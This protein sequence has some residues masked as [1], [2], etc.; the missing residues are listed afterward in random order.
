M[1][2]AEV[3]ELVD[4]LVEEPV[5]DAV[6]L[7]VVLDLN[8]VSVNHT[9]RKYKCDIKETY[10]VSLD[11]LIGG[12]LFVE[13]DNRFG[14]VGRMLP[15]SSSPPDTAGRLGMRLPKLAGTTPI[16]KPSVGVDE[17]SLVEPL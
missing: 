13:L 16:F 2:E 12:W 6:E 10:L 9:R 4:V 8:A 5:E 3:E 7:E 11:V 17:L 14:R 15:G 1:L